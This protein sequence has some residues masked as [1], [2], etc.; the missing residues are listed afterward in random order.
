MNKLLICDD[1]ML[2]RNM[3]RRILKDVPDLE[4]VEALNGLQGVAMY[5]SEK[6]DMVTMDITMNYKNGLQAAQEILQWDPKAKIVMVTALG[7]EDRIQEGIRIGVLDFI[8]K[9]FTSERVLETVK[10]V[11]EI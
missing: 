8:I 5:K 2:I 4:F 3:I 11:L 9:P 10:R 7:L 6:P 1:S